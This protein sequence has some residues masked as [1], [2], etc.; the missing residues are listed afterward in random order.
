MF[1][2]C[3]FY[4]ARRLQPV[5]GAVVFYSST[6]VSCGTECLF[7]TLGVL[8]CLDAVRSLQLLQP[9]C[10]LSGVRRVKCEIASCRILCVVIN[11]QRANVHF[12]N[13]FAVLHFYALA[14]IG[15]FRVM[16]FYICYSQI[17]CGVIGHW[18]C[19]GP[20]STSSG[21]SHVARRSELVHSSHPCCSCCVCLGSTAA[22]CSHIRPGRQMA[23]LLGR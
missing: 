17:L 15:A 8:V 9:G 18:T 14:I 22:T 16:C 12:H 5:S 21:R 3:M 10:R 4:V 7:F 2:C 1:V 19:K 20:I 6:R 13:A 23:S 11:L